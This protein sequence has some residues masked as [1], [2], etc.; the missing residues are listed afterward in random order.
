MGDEP[1]VA[2]S[3]HWCEFWYPYGDDRL[4]GLL[5]WA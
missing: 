1:L 5:G 3:H 2:T 4:V